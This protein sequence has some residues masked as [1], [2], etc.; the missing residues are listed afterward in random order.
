MA[1]TIQDGTP[2]DGADSY[3]TVA[4][5]DTYIDRRGYTD[6]GTDADKEV[7]LVKAYDFMESLT[8]LQ[9]HDYAFTI[10]DNMSPAN[11]EI[12]YR[13]SQGFDPFIAPDQ[14]VLSE[15]VDTL[16]VTYQGG[17]AQKA[18]TTP[19]GKLQTMPQALSLL[20]SL[21]RGESNQMLRA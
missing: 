9:N 20:K 2:L 5:Y 18:M 19:F 21:V 7:S 11:C 6:A 1:L 10:K 13:I 4:E 12:A 15:Q 3:A 17:T 14:K 8:W 16:S